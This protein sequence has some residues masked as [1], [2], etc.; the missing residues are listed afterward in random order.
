MHAQDIRAKAQEFVD[1]DF[2]AKEN[3]DRDIN[4]EGMKLFILFMGQL[5][6]AASSIANTLSSGEIKTRDGS[7]GH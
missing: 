1:T 5:A 6:A 4:T 3:A 2:D 7:H